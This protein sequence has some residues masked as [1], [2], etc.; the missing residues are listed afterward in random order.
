MNISTPQLV[1][2]TLAT[3]NEPDDYIV[4]RVTPL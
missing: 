2:S 4:P 3:Y 1:K